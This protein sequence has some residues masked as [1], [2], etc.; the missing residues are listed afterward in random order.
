ML[1]SSDWHKCVCGT[2]IVVQADELEELIKYYTDRGHFG[3]VIDLMECAMRLERTHI[4]ECLL[5]WEYYIQDSKKK[6]L[7]EHIKLFHSLD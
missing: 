7:M 6:K 3:E 1:N 4:W 2:N 5:N